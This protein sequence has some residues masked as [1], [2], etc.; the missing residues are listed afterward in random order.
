[1]A[2]RLDHFVFSV[3]PSPQAAGRPIPFTVRVVDAFEEPVTNFSGSVNLSAVARTNQIGVSVS[4]A[5]SR[6]S[7][8]AFGAAP[9]RSPRQTHLVVLKVSDALEHAGE[10]ISFDVLTAIPDDRHTASVRGG[11]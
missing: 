7:S 10:S 6:T 5:A 8:R 9:R 1:V 11:R 3:I 2:G 4:P